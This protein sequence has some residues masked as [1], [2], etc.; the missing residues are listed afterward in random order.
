LF[1]SCC[2]S[3]VT[4][5]RF[6]ADNACSFPYKSA[7]IHAFLLTRRLRSVRVQQ[8]Y[9]ANTKQRVRRQRASESVAQ[10]GKRR[11][12]QQQQPPGGRSHLGASQTPAINGRSSR[13]SLVTARKPNVADGCYSA[14]LRLR[15]RLCRSPSLSASGALVGRVA[16]SPQRRRMRAAIR[17]A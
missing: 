6:S 12:R 3:P 17:A 16:V 7:M 11:H 15:R 14:Q 9:D 2:S 10:N 1:T 8:R 4:W 13:K 5:D